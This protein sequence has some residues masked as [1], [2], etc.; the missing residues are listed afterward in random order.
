M[1]DKTTGPKTSSLYRAGLLST[2]THSPS[3]VETDYKRYACLNFS[4]FLPK[5]GV[6]S[7]RKCK[8]SDYV[9]FK[10]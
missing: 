5:V 10:T 3:R 4:P 6:S 8:L 1:R 2:T 9:Y 7:S